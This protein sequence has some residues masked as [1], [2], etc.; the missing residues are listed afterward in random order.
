MVVTSFPP[1]STA[2]FRFRNVFLPAG[3][4]CRVSGMP[5]VDVGSCAGPQLANGSGGKCSPVGGRRSL[6]L[7]YSRGTFAMIE[8][9]NGA[10]SW[11]PSQTC[12]S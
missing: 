11:F 12:C 4:I 6:L 5:L 2:A 9:G 8:Q 3:E 1:L 10:F 7:R